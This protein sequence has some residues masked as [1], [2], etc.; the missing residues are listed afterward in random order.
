MN[1]AQFP[2]FV[3]ENT[4][5]G[6]RCA[7]HS[8]KHLLRY[9]ENHLLRLGFL[10]VASEQQKS[11]GQPFL[12]GIEKLIDQILLD[13]DVPRKH[14]RHEAVGESMFGVEQANHLVFL[15]NEYRRGRNRGRCPH[16][17]RLTCDSSLTKKV[18]WSQNRQDRFFADLIDDRELYTAF[19]N[20]HHARSGI[21]LRVDLLQSS[22]FHNASRYAG[23]IEKSLSIESALL[24]GFSFG[25][26]AGR[27]RDFLHN[28]TA[29]QQVS[30]NLEAQS[31]INDWL[32]A[33]CESAVPWNVFQNGWHYFLESEAFKWLAT[34]YAER[35][36]QRLDLFPLRARTWTCAASPF[37]S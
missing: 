13:S 29:C 12:A 32:V 22:I 8:R 11:A 18:T 16:S 14:I 34:A 24:R 2:E 20:V 33:Q 36:V 35:F 30:H 37:L 26:N 6:A 7:N 10:T 31:K 15:N 25:F 5:I 28:A 17:D 4:H 27:T 3:H 21:T 23:R 19:L 1:E 9:F